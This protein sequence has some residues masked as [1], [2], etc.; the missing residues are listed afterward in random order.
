MEKKIPTRKRREVGHPKVSI[1]SLNRSY[2]LL[3]EV[4][5][6]N[7]PPRFAIFN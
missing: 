1:A 7:F 3:F 2:S 4:F 6:C 5:I